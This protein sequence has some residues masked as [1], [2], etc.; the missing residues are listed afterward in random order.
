M[1]L[2]KHKCV[3]ID[4]C[5]KMGESDGLAA[6]VYYFRGCWVTVMDAVYLHWMFVWCGCCVFVVDIVCL[7]LDAVLLLWM[8][9]DCNGCFVSAVDVCIC[10]GCCV[11]V[12]DVICML[13]MLCV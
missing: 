12:V 8:L 10:Y 2:S 6:G 7:F 1:T 13:R 5:W 9:S 4:L 3:T 11:L